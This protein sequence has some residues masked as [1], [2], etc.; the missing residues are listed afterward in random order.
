MIYYWHILLF[1][2]LQPC[3][4]TTNKVKSKKRTRINANN[5]NGLVQTESFNEENS[6]SENAQT[7]HST[8]VRICYILF[9]IIQIGDPSAFA[10]FWINY[11]K[12]F[13]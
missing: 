6:T 2:L 11:S 12:L 10:D 1:F 13:L 4:S 9:I 3:I 8:S 5:S 7:I